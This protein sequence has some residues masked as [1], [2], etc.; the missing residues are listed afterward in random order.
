VG[1]LSII[2]ENLNTIAYKAYPRG[3]KFHGIVWF[4]YGKLGPVLDL[5]KISRRTYGKFTDFHGYFHGK[6][7]ERW[8]HKIRLLG[9][10]IYKGN[11]DQVAPVPR[12]GS[13]SMGCDF[14]RKARRL[15]ETLR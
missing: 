5:Y 9:P 12:A 10:R 3:W 11:P 13:N 15:Y 4:V 1:K 6:L 2:S 8:I 7:M 14:H